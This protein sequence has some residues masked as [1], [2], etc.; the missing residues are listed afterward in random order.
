MS[1][2]EQDAILNVVIGPNWRN[3]LSTYG[4]GEVNYLYQH[5]QGQISRMIDRINNE[6]Y[7]VLNAGH[8]IWNSGNAQTAQRH[9]NSFIEHYYNKFPDSIKVAPPKTY[10]EMVNAPMQDPQGTQVVSAG[11]VVVTPSIYDQPGYNPNAVVTEPMVGMQSKDGTVEFVPQSQVSARQSQGWG[12]IGGATN[13]QIAAANNID[14]P[15]TSTTTGT[16]PPTTT[17][18]TSPPGTTTIQH[19]SST[20]VVPTGD[21][22]YWQSQGWSVVGQN[23]ATATPAGSAS[24]VDP[25]YLGMRYGQTNN[26]ASNY[27]ASLALD[28]FLTLLS[29]KNSVGI[30][31]M[32][33]ENVKND[34]ALLGK[35]I[36]AL[37]YGGYTLEDVYKDIKRMDMVA[38][39]DA[40]MNNIEIISTSS[41]K[42]TY[43][44]TPAG[45]QA[46]ANP[47]LTMPTNLEGIS[48]SSLFKLKL[49]QMPTWMFEE[50]VPILDTESDEFKAQLDTIKTAYHDAIMMQLKA[51]NEREKAV[52]D[53]TYEQLKKTI[54]EN[55][56]LK[57][58]D[59]A[60]EAWNQIESIG[61]KMGERG[62][63]GSGME[64]EALDD[65]LRQVREN[66]RRTRETQLNSEETYLAQKLAA[67]GSPDEIQA[68]IAEDQAKGLPREEWRAVKWGLVPSQEVLDA[69]SVERLMQEYDIDRETAEGYRNK[70]LDENGNYR[71]TIYQNYYS[72]LQEA[73]DSKLATQ[74]TQLFAKNM[75][76]AERK[77]WNVTNPALEDIYSTYM[78]AGAEESVSDRNLATN[79]A[80]FQA[81]QPQTTTPQ[82]TQSTTQT[83]TSGLSGDA[84]SAASAAASSL[85]SGQYQTNITVPTNWTKSADEWQKTSDELNIAYKRSLGSDD[86]KYATDKANIAYAQKT[87]N[88]QPTI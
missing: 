32:T 17:L 20:N 59:N 40:S 26:D 11:G 58:S 84:A 87:Y 67:S 60:L 49:F 85:G 63:M 38:K 10:A 44:K 53:Y 1:P 24:T 64:N 5:A 37:A 22:A 56:N 27:D 23:G 62:L 61:A 30:D 73:K 57:L 2:Q 76:E 72:Q 21:V 68:L 7:N 39:G 41:D 36:I 71:S 13:E 6:V 48:D 45:Q 81:T 14:L 9:L 3:S 78:P 28:G 46:L 50:L 88:W 80:A 55:Y 83:S 19:G 75:E 35:Y 65:Y 25:T 16:T 15:S 47:Y 34:P 86:P 12:V 54:E 74:R 43:A 29:V 31:V 18:P 77:Y 4:W 33:F 70:V 82:T 66:D 8:D 52:A 69:F 79:L 42:D 51:T